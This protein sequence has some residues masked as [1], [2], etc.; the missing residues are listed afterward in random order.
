MWSLVRAA[1]SPLLTNYLLSVFRLSKSERALRK[2][3]HLLVQK[4]P[5]GP[6]ALQNYPK[7][8]VCYLFRYAVRPVQVAQVV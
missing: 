7:A 3:G 8:Q 4:L 1:C 6:G 2:M 5:K